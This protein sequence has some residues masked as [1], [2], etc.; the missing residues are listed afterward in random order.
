MN[1]TVKQRQNSNKR[2]EKLIFVLQ[3]MYGPQHHECTFWELGG[4]GREGLGAN[5]DNVRVDVPFGIW[6]T[7]KIK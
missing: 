5:S 2:S 4:E 6:Q 7:H 3:S 1:K